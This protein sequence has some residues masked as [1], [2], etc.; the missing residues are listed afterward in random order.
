MRSEASLAMLLAAGLSASA[1]LQAQNRTNATE[2]PIVAEK[3]FVAGGRIEMH[4]DGG[5]YAIRPAAGDHIR[6]TTSGNTGNAKVELTANGTDADVQVKDTPHNNFQATIEVPKAADLV[7]RLSGGE[8]VIAAIRGTKTSRATE[9]TLRSR[10]AIPTITRAW[11][12]PSRPATLTPACLASPSPGSFS[13]SRGPD[14]ESTHSVPIW[15]PV[16]WRC[17]ANKDHLNA[18][19]KIRSHCY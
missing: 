8:L 18:A 7:V 14:T 13:I 1:C 3:P 5:G 11:T 12:H 10:L 9:E 2:K 4:L 19:P 15:A 16:I 17:E 6:V